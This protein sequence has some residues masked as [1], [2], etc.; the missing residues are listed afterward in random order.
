MSDLAFNLSGKRIWVA[1]H[2]GMVGSAVVR[3]LERL[4]T[5][6]VVTA[7]RDLVDLTR[8]IEVERWTEQN[9]PDVVIMAAARVGGIKA[10]DTRPGEFIYEN[11]AIQTNVIHAAHRTGV[12]K[13]LFL[14]SSCIYPR[15]VAQPMSEDALLTAPLE[16]TNQWYA[17]AK[18]AGIKMCQA[19]RRQYGRDFISVMPTN[20]YGPGDNFNLE[21]SHVLPA[22]LRK[23]HGAKR[24]GRDEVVIWGT[25]TP[26]REFMYVEDLADALIFLLEHYS[27]EEHINVGVGS[28]ISIRELAET[29]ADAVGYR[30]RF[31]YDTS[32]PDG[33]PRKLMDSSRLT[34]LG[35]QAKTPLADG[36]RLTYEWFLGNE[37]KQRRTEAARG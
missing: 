13:L 15:D 6:T 20:L 32:M 30:G 8:Q 37:E 28:D 17:V 10:N 11:L 31:V 25:G 34:A 19:Y 4:G 14:G 23:I 33:T 12:R 2:R 9:R 22:L 3:R 29:I 18:I 5:C 1:G 27:G 24:E 21:S 7:E 16:P 36:V 35:W 26:K